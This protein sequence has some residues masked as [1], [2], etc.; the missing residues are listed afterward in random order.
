MIVRF[1]ILPWLFWAPKRFRGFQERGPG[2][3]Q[4]GLPVED[5]I[6]PPDVEESTDTAQGSIVNPFGVSF[7]LMK[8]YSL[9]LVQRI[10]HTEGEEEAKKKTDLFKFEK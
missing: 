5:F 2:P 7:E 3:L 8:V 10:M 6:Q 9:S 4:D 1:E